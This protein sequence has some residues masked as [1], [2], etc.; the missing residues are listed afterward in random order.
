MKILL[1]AKSAAAMGCIPERH[2]SLNQKALAQFGTMIEAMG[3]TAIGNEQGAIFVSV[4]NSTPEKV[5]TFL[6]LIAA[7]GCV[8][9]PQDAFCY[10]QRNH[11]EAQEVA[12]YIA[13]QV[14]SDVLLCE[15]DQVTETFMTLWK[16]AGTP[17]R[18][19][20][21]EGGSDPLDTDD[22][23][24]L[25]TAK[26]NNLSREQLE[27]LREWGCEETAD[28]TYVLN[29]QRAAADWGTSGL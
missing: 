6:E 4:S 24:V 22:E 12:R 3:I 17:K 14:G 21:F 29:Q 10:L 1:S 25:R 16:R 26:Y 19:D 23:T 13:S 28:E 5:N 27:E 18:P 7:S 15:P 11:G 2:V 9:E 8:I 20:F